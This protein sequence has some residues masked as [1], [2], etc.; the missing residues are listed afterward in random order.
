MRMREFAPIER[1]RSAADRNLGA[2]AAR[3]VP[4]AIVTEDFRKPRRSTGVLAEGILMDGWL[5]R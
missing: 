4:A 3:A 2:V 5:N 1:V